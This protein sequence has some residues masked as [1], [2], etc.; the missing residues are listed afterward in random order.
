MNVYHRLIAVL[1]L[2]L[3]LA[4]PIPTS[5]APPQPAN[6]APLLTPARVEYDADTRSAYCRIGGTEIQVLLWQLGTYENFSLWKN[7]KLLFQY[8][9]PVSKP[10]YGDVGAF[11]SGGR[12]F[13]YYHSNTEL[14]WE[15]NSHISGH[16]VIVGKSPVTGEYRVYLDS[17][18]YYNPSP[19][20]YQVILGHAD[21]DGE[22]IMR[23]GF[24]KGLFS[25]IG[26]VIKA[27][28]LRYDP[29]SDSFV[30]EER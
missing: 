10:S 28:Y 7:K 15:P 2:A 23:L 13:F 24:G 6:T 17:T 30:Y 9:A 12:T 11:T 25:E 8:M 4:A 21:L 20:E 22:P 26:A 14:A 3:L 18:D 27:Y 1:T 29:R 19:D 5:A 16:A